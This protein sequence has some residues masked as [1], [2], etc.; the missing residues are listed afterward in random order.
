MLTFGLVACSASARLP[1]TSTSSPATSTSSPA[2]STSSAT[3]HP[4]ATTHPAQPPLAS[5]PVILASD[6]AADEQALRSPS[7]SDA[8]LAAAAQRQQAAYRALGRHPEWDPIVRPKIP[9]SLLD[10][11]DRNVDARRHLGALSGGEAKDT[12]PAWRIDAPAPADALLGYYH[13]ADAATGVGWNY[14]AAINLIETAFG[15]IIG[16]STAGAD[17]PMQFLPSTF[18]AYGD[19]SD[20]HSP[21]D[22]IMAAGRFL[23]ANGFA[24]DHD[25]AIFVYNHSGHYVSAVD[26][27][28]AMIASDPAAFA[29]YYRW[30]VYYN[31][32][33]GDVLLPI[34]YAEAERIPVAGYLASHPQ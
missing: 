5:D 16:L 32:S 6:L 34:G 14:L 31:T 19:G 23:A 29:G 3:P 17:G 22:S 13:E 15:R 9:P 10:A 4:V 33:S 26:D 20:I 30:D 28:A 11:Y 27:Y 2:T 1:A 25:H 7:S 12:L 21:H 8:A 24:G 18:A